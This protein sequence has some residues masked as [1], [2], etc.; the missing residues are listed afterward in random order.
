[1]ADLILITNNPL[2]AEYYNGKD[3]CQIRWVDSPVIGVL[4]AAR[5]A[6]HR[7]AELVSHPLSGVNKPGASPYKSVV[8]TSPSTEAQLHFQ[9]LKLI[10]EAIAYYKKNPKS[11]FIH[12]DEETLKDF[13]VIDLDM[14]VSS[15]I[16]QQ[17]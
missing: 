10:E 8:V 17:I 3:F 2:V 14:V 11:R 4:T 13:Q 7:G 16:N 1:M 6:V 9:S 12:I 5:S 15:L